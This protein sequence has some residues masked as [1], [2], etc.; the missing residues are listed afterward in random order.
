MTR[1]TLVIGALITLIGTGAFMLSRE[2]GA[3]LIAIPGIGM[4]LLRQRHIAALIVSTM[5]MIFTAS[6]VPRLVRMILGETISQP[7]AV[8]AVAMA[9]VLFLVH[10]TMSVRWLVATKRSA[11][12]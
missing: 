6:S 8:V 3:V 12:S 7:V 5:S 9:S 10:V 11:T 4:I 2:I 1:S